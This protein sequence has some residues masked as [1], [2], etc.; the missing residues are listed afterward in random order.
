MGNFLLV[1][2]QVDMHDRLAMALQDDLT[3]RIVEDRRPRRADRY[4]LARHGRF[5]HRPDDRQHR[6]DVAGYS[7]P[8]RWW[9]A[10][11]RRSR[12]RWSSWGCRCRAS[13]PPWTSRRGWTAARRGS[14]QATEGTSMSVSKTETLPI[15][16]RTTSCWFARPCASGRSSAGSAWSTRPR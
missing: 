6:R 5:V 4:L 3:T 13:A 9:S 15:R 10:C 7:T 11:S 1:T 14:G 16:A 12:S 8:R 2:I